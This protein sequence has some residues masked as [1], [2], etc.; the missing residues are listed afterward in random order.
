MKEQKEN[1]GN[2]MIRG[3][4]LTREEHKASDKDEPYGPPEKRRRGTGGE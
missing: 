4:K 2:L 1:E 3:R